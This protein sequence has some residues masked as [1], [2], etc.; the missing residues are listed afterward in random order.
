MNYFIQHQIDT[1]QNYIEILITP[2]KMEVIKKAA[3]VDTSE[4]SDKRELFY[5]MN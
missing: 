3:P 5:S 1:N 4:N 2:F